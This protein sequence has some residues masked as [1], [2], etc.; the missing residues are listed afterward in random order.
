MNAPSLETQLS[1]LVERLNAGD[2]SQVRET[3]R[4]LQ[5]RYPRN[6]TLWIIEGIAARRQGRNDDAERA[7]VQ[8]LKLEPAHPDAAF[9]LGNLLRDQQQ[10]DRALA[11][12]LQA[13]TVHRPTVD[14]ELALGEILMQQA[15]WTEAEAHF[16]QALQLQ[17]GLLNAALAQAQCRQQ[18]GDSAAART[19]LRQLAA[20]R[21]DDL[22]GLLAIEQCLLEMNHFDD[23]E[24]VLRQAIALSPG[25]ASL[26]HNLGALFIRQKRIAEAL[27]CFERAVELGLEQPQTLSNLAGCLTLQGQIQEAVPVL[28]RLIAIEPDN[29]YAHSSLHFILAKLCIWD[30][31]DHLRPMLIEPALRGQSSSDPPLPFI[32]QVLPVPISEQEQQTIAHHFAAHVMKQV[33]CD[34]FDFSAHPR[35]G[36]LRIGYLSADF[37]NHATS[38]LMLGLFKRHD[39]Q[40]FEIYAYSL[41]ADD[42]TFYRQRIRQEV[43]H[44]VD[45][46]ALSHHDAAQRIFAD[47]IDIL[48]DLKGYTRDSRPEILAQRPAPLQLAWLGYPGTVGA[49]FIDFMLTD[50]IVTPAARQPFYDEKFAYLPQCY[51]IN[52]CEQ[53][54]AAEIPTR[55][56]CAL[57]DSGF[58][59]CCFCALYK[60]EPVIFAVWMDL[61]KAV[62]GSVL[63]LLNGHETAKQ[64]LR[65]AASAAGVDPARLIFAPHQDK[66]RHLA[67]HAH[68][69]LFLDTYFCNAHTTASDALW[70]GLPVITC[71]RDTFAT[72][73]GASLLTYIGLAE[74]IAPTLDAYRELALSYARAPDKLAQLKQRLR[75]QRSSAPL[76]DTGGFTRELENLL[77]QL[78]LQRFP[79]EAEART[80]DEILQQALSAYQQ[81]DFTAALA[82]LQPLLLQLPLRPDLWNFLGVLNRKLKH[83]PLAYQA[84]HRALELEPGHA[85]SLANL[86]NVCRDLERYDEAISAYQQA[87]RARPDTIGW[88]NDLGAAL[89]TQ[90][91]LDEALSAHRQALALD[92]NSADTQWEYAL[93]LLMAGQWRSGFDAYRARWTR[94]QPEPPNFAQP[95]WQ[96]E[97]LEDQTLLLYVEQGYGDALQFL[98]FLPLVFARVRHVVLEVRPPLAPVVPPLPGLRVIAGGQE[99]LPPFDVHAGLMDL[100]FLLADDLAQMPRH[101]PYIAAPPERL[102]PWRAR[103]QAL[104]G[105][106]VGLVWGGNPD[107]KSDRMRSP[108]LAPLLPLLRIPGISFVC[109]QQGDGRRDLQS[110]VLPEG[111]SW[112]DPSSEI[113]DF[114]DTAAIMA[115]LDLVISSDTGPAH[116]AGALGVPLWVLLSYAGDWRWGQDPVDAFW[117]PSA[118][119]FRQRQPGDWAQVIQDVSASIG[120]LLAPDTLPFDL[121]Q[122]QLSAQRAYAENRDAEVVEIASRL[123]QRQPGQAANWLLRGAGLRRQGD[124]RAAERDLIEALRRIPLYADGH[125]Q[126]LQLLHSEQRWL[127]AQ[128]AATRWTGLMPDSAEAWWWLGLSQESANLQQAAVASYQH[129]LQLDPQRP[130]LKS[131]LALCLNAA[132]ANALAEERLADGMGYLRR[133]LEYH[134]DF[135]IARFNLGLGLLMQ[136]AYR[137]GFAAYEAR[138]QLPQ[139]PKPPYP[140]L[141]YWEGE[142]ISG[143][144]VLLYPEQGFGDALQFVR[145]AQTLR[146]RGAMV[147]VSLQDSLNRLAD[148]SLSGIKVLRRGDPMPP[149]DYQCALPSLPHR[150]DITL[151]ELPG[152]MPYMRAPDEALQRWKPRI[153]ALPGLK[154][155]LIWAGSATFMNEKLRSPRMAPLLPLLAIPGISFVC[156]QQGDGRR[157]LEQWLPPPGVSWLDAAAEISDFADTAAVMSSLDLIISSDTGPAHL[158]GSLNVPLWLLLCHGPDWRWGFHGERSP[159]YPSARLFRQKKSGDWSLPVQQIAE[160]LHQRLPAAPN[161]GLP[162]E[163]ILKALELGKAEQAES[164]S[165]ARLQQTP[166]AMGWVILGMS[167]RRQ[168]KIAD[169]CGAYR[170]ALELDAANVDAWY[171]LG[172][173]EIQRQR[174]AEAGVAYGHCVAL[175][176]G[177]VDAWIALSDALRHAGQFA[178]AIDAGLRACAL[179]PAQAETWNNLGNAYTSARQIDQAEPAY[180]RAIE[181]NAEFIDG[182]YNLGV[183][184]QQRG[185]HREA[186]PI[187]QH[188]LAQRPQQIS[189]RYNLA[190]AEQY[191]GELD[192]AEADYLSIIEADA[193]HADAR[194]NLGSLY[195]YRNRPATALQWYLA[196]LALRDDLP[197]RGEIAHIRQKQCDWSDLSHLRSELV[198]PSLVTQEKPPSPFSM[199]VLPVPISEQEQLIIARHHARFVMDQ[200]E[201]ARFDFSQR[202]AHPRLRIGYLS[203]DFH[204]HA[205]SHLMLGLF[206]RHDR[207]QFAIHAYSIGPDDGSFYRQRIGQEVDHFVDLRSLPAPEA[208]QRIFDDEIDILIDLK[209]YTRDSRPE[210]LAQRPAPLQ[211]AWLGYPGTT[212]APFVDFMLTDRIVTP[213]RCQP[214]YDERF[215]YLPQ[216]YQINDCEQDI[217]EQAP[218]RAACGLPEQGFVF[219]CFCA[220]YKIEPVIFS[221]WMDLLQAVPDSVLWLLDGYDIS[222]DN[223]RAACRAAGVDPAR[224]VFAPVESKASHLARHVH[225]DLFL[226]TY[227]C[228]AH[229]TASDAL[230]AGLPV[231][232]CPQDTFAT[233]VCASLLTYIG[234]PEL[235]CA[236]L[237]AYRD[238][239]LS[240]ARAPQQLAALKRKLQQQR[241]ST[242]LFDTD[243]FTRGL[244]AV[245]AQLWRE[246]GDACAAAG[247]ELGNFPAQPAPETIGL[248]AIETA[249]P[250]QSNPHG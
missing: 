193:T 11:A 190:I 84:Y 106:K 10:W 196:G 33:A 71:P 187:Y 28:K 61:L 68:A 104:P 65:A 17:P 182:W 108:R 132:G 210:I 247:R 49:P 5:K 74:L 227:F 220:L 188:V 134:P 156:L 58:V 6:A 203:A 242:P 12:Y 131:R 237:A 77:R 191:S 46:Q 250:G 22:P 243:S 69:D 118:R 116:L 126:L 52:D 9:N 86:G 60:T 184:Q 213:P 153:Q 175:S 13:L 239:A 91:R 161:P 44:F 94:R 90:H 30:S 166:D 96:G 167:L 137:E 7:Y 14:V 148:A 130:Q 169:A 248:F 37:H 189:A 41:S 178:E 105:L 89:V 138:R 92:P 223:L 234:L 83:Y 34:R 64:N 170:Q 154:V 218:T 38:H 15:R 240:Y 119:L 217:A 4:R 202:P 159:W 236:S 181:L 87:L 135:A 35:H 195:N 3:G 168:N 244:E 245:L 144:H 31:L 172:N 152:P 128:A 208:A 102:P 72:R 162:L 109:L 63:W 139:I 101:V 147:Y 201:C 79:L 75:Q 26:Q 198:E 158:A 226:D 164:L 40:R 117:Y 18:S 141:P 124:M 204:N 233:R 232:T 50:R 205:T 216:C 121:G 76:F 224:L 150:L 229:T 212:G 39:R 163:P 29:L 160:A 21:H 225:A 20:Q 192:A 47:E 62:P 185:H 142:S 56:E 123:I 45:L 241:L 230:W 228:N 24:A 66:A 249:A 151:Q 120:S 55:A 174:W 25:E 51:Q 82:C 16:T 85:E 81:E 1:Q 200:V 197:T 238:L 113:R 176:P 165:R 179:H 78:W 149:I 19:A 122:W 246:H 199:L 115:E 110:G 67:R 99:A 112:Y 57:P 93:A 73:V 207:L 206:K 129:L 209:G 111:I 157:D 145:F 133:S 173:A 43:D 215:A 107:V 59:F 183:L 88:L 70:A 103:L 221:V 177:R 36:R 143:R 114:G 222:K 32:Y 100:A 95:Q 180:R 53:E 127:D 27:P 80:T 214:F 54:I 211:V 155:G 146:A 48:I 97:K 231:I 186:I 98:R 219:C 8:A 42:G 235:I 125:K 136:G 194:F 171:N 23:A 2:Y 140:S